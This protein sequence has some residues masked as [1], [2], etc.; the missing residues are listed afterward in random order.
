MISLG[1]KDI[2]IDDIRSVL[3]N[4]TKFNI[5]YTDSNTYLSKD[6]NY[7]PQENESNLESLFA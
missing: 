7:I 1:R 6:N 2:A 5:I 3:T 4:K